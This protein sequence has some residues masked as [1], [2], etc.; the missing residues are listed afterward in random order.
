MCS[1]LPLMRQR[2]RLTPPC[3]FPA[4]KQACTVPTATACAER[5]QSAA[6]VGSAL[7]RWTMNG[8]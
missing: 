4:R 1:Y 8:G 6:F 2:H 7:G 3:R 5:F